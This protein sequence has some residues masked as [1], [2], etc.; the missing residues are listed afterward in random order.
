MNNSELALRLQLTQARNEGEKVRKDLKETEAK[1]TKLKAKTEA[2]KKELREERKRIL[3]EKEEAARMRDQAFQSVAEYKMLLQRAQL[4]RDA[5]AE[6]RAKFDRKI[7]MVRIK[8]RLLQR[9]VRSYDK[10]L[11][12][13]LLQND[14]AKAAIVQGLH[15]ERARWTGK[16]KRMKAERAEMVLELER[17]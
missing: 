2:E 13:V 3:G 8:Q 7:G 11:E 15:T 17:M 14:E 5:F 9:L 6:E 1:Y 4:E 10:M 12:Q 16:K